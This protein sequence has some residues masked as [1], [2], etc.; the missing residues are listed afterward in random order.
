MSDPIVEVRH[1]SVHRGGQRLLDDVNF[2]VERGQIHA[3]VGH[4]GAGK[5]TLIQA[6]LGA[7]PFDGEIA[8]HFAAEG[9]IGYVPQRLHVDPGLPLTV[10]D[11]LALGRQRRPICSGLGAATRRAIT[12]LLEEVHLGPLL[13][14]PLHGLSGGELQRVL[15]VEALHPQ[16]ELLILDEAAAGLDQAS[17]LRFEDRVKQA[18]DAGT[19]VLLVAHEEAQLARL[20]DA[21]TYL[22]EG[23]VA[24]EVHPPATATTELH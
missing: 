7:L 4:N 24:L 2:S 13:D 21:R 8:L 12:A 22:R 5:S 9:R 6:L 11:F 3:L 18:R 15:L 1:L 10:A 14:R 23:R 17:V 20:S 16:P 19:T